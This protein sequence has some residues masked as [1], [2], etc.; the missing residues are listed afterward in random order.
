MINSKRPAD[1]IKPAEVIVPPISVLPAPTRTATDTG[2]PDMGRPDS[3]PLMIKKPEILDRLVKI[4]GAKRKDAKL[5]LEATLAVLG[6]ALSEGEELNLP[7]LG[8]IKVNRT[9]Q[10]GAA[11]VLILK[12]RRG[13]GKL[14]GGAQQALEHDSQDD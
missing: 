1:K 4:S 6:D 13:G 14:D 2:K 8:K 5:I 12:L 10:D 3:Q 9:R 11:E 7:P